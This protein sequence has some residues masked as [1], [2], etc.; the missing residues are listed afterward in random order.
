MAKHL[1]ISLGVT[2]D[3]S[4]AKAQLQDL[5]NQLTKI[6]NSPTSNRMDLAKEIRE[7][8]QAAAELQAHLKNAT[9]VDTGTL[10]FTKLSSSLKQSGQSLESYA[11]KLVRI[12]PEGRQAFQQLTTSVAQSEIPIKRVNK[13]LTEMWTTLKNSARWQISSSILHGFMGSVSKAYGYAQD[14]N[15]SLTNIRIVTGQ[16]TDQMA[17]FAKQANAAAK[18]L[19]TTTTK[20]TN[21]SLIY[22][23]QGLSDEEVKKR[24]DITVKMAN[25]A[26]ASAETVSD[27]LTAVWN[28]FY[29]GTKSLEHYADVMTAL[30]AA[31]ASSTDEIAG[32]LEKFAAVADTIGL[33]YEYAAS[34]LATITSNTRQSEEVVGTALKTIFARIQGLNLGETLEDGTSLNKYSAALE[35]VGISIFD[36]TG[37]LKEMD[38]ILDEL[39]NKWQTL[40]KDQQVA[41]A[42][43]VAGVRQ[44][45]QLVSLMDNWNN[46]DNDSF[47]ANLNTAKNSEG[48]LQEQADIYAEGW[49]AA[50]DRV[51]ASMEG[52][53]ETIMDDDAFI[54]VLNGIAEVVS[55]VDNL[56]D[57]M[58]GLGG[59]VATVGAVMTKVFSKQMAQSLRDT[60]YSLTMMTEK[61]RD[62]A[63]Q[64]KQTQLDNLTNVA[65]QSQGKYK[66]EETSAWIEGIESTSRAQQAYDNAS[67]HMTPEQAR[68]AQA[69]MDELARR[70]KEI[71]E[72]AKELDT[73]KNANG[74][75]N[76]IVENAKRSRAQELKNDGGNL[77]SDQRK[78]EIEKT[79]QAISKQY[80]EIKKKYNQ[81][82]A[83]IETVINKNT[84]F[85]DSE[86]IEK[87]DRILEN[88]PQL[89]NKVKT[90]GEWVELEDISDEMAND[91]FNIRK[92]LVEEVEEALRQV[93]KNVSDDLQINDSTL[94]TI[95]EGMVG[96]AV[97]EEKIRSMKDDRDNFNKE[98]IDAMNKITPTI[99]DWADKTVAISDTLFTLTSSIQ[100]LKGINE[101]IND[102]TLSDWDKFISI[103][104]TLTMNIP[105]LINSITNLGTAFG[106]VAGATK[107]LNAAAVKLVPGFTAM[108]T[109][110]GALDLTTKGLTYSLSA[111]W[112]NLLPVI[113]VL[114][115]AAVAIG[116]VYS[117]LTKEQRAADEAAESA[118]NL[119]NA[120]ESAK[121]AH[122]AFKETLG[123]YNEEK[124]ALKDLVYGTEEYKE[125]LKQANETALELI[126]TN[127]YLKDKYY[128]D[129]KGAIQFADNALEEV[130]AQKEQTRNQAE[131]TS[132]YAKDYA[133][134]L[135][136]K[137][138]KTALMRADSSGLLTK[139]LINQ[140]AE[141]F[142][143]DSTIFDKLEAGKFTEVAELLKVSDNVVGVL[144]QHK[145]SLEQLVVATNN[146]EATQ[147]LNN[148]LLGQA[149]FGK[150]IENTNLD[151]SSKQ[152]LLA[153]ILGDS[154]S[155]NADKYQNQYKYLSY[156]EQESFIENYAREQG[157]ASSKISLNGKAT[158]Y[159]SQGKEVSSLTR[160]DLTSIY[161]Y[162]K[163]LEETSESIEKLAEIVK[164]GTENLNDAQIE[165]LSTFSDEKIGDLSKLTKKEIEDLAAGLEDGFDGLTEAIGATDIETAFEQA[166]TNLTEAKTEFV[167][168]LA[169][170]DESTGLISR[171]IQNAFNELDTSNVSLEGSKAIGN[172]LKNAF[173][174]GGSEG[175][176]VAKTLFAAAGDKAGEVANI[177]SSIDWQ[178]ATVETLNERL[179][180]AGIHI[181]QASSALAKFVDWI[182]KVRGAASAASNSEFYNSTQEILEKMKS[183]GTITEEEMSV[184]RNGS[185]EMK[186]M[187]DLFQYN[188]DGTY[189]Y[190][191]TNADSYQAEQY[192]KEEYHNR[193]GKSANEFYQNA[194]NIKAL[195]NVDFEALTNRKITD[196]ATTQQRILA[197]RELMWD[198]LDKKSQ[199][200]IAEFEKIL[201]EG[202]TL[203]GRQQKSLTNILDKNS[204]LF[205][206]GSIDAAY[207]DNMFEANKN[208]QADFSTAES[209][210]Q[211]EEFLKKYE[212]VPGAIEAA[213]K[214]IQK[215]NNELLSDE[216]DIEKEELDKLA[217][218]Y[219]NMGDSAEEAYKKAEEALKLN[220]GLE[221]LIDNWKTYNKVLQEGSESSPQFIQTMDELQTILSNITGISDKELFTKDWIKKNQTTL[222]QLAKGS[223]KAIDK[224]RKAAADEILVK[225][226]GV[227][228]FDQVADDFKYLHNYL[229]EY[230]KNNSIEVG[231]KID[232]A[233]FL[234][235]CNEIIAAAGFTAEQA[236]EY[237]KAL[238][239]N[240]E[241]ETQEK[242]EESETTF[243]GQWFDETT[244]EIK[245]INTTLKKKST[246]KVPVV[247]SITYTGEAGGK[248]NFSNTAAGGA[249]SS[250]SGGGSSDEPTKMEY[251]KEI[252]FYDRYKEWDDALDDIDDLLS[253]IQKKEDSLYGN[254]KISAMKNRNKVLLKEVEA[255]QQKKKEAEAYF[256]IDK[257]N[258]QNAAGELGYNIDF[259]SRDQILNYTSTMQGLFDELHAMEEHFNSLGS[260]K[261]QQEYK[262][263]VMDPFNQ[264]VDDLKT[265]I[266]QYDE[267]RELLEDLENDIDDSILEWKGLNYE[268]LHY[269]MEIKIEINDVALERLDYYLSKY[270]DDFYSLAEAASTLFD[271]LT[272]TLNKLRAY[273][274]FY[275]DTTALW[276]ST[277]QQ[278]A[279]IVDGVTDATHAA[280]AERLDA[281][282]GGLIGA[283]TGEGVINNNIGDYYQ[284][285]GTDNLDALS[286]DITQ[287]DYAE[288]LKEVI[289]GM[290]EELGNLDE[291]DK[292]F[293]EFY[294]SALDMAREELEF[295]TGSLTHLT[296]ALEHYQKVADI[297]GRTNDY[298]FM[299]K[300]LDAQAKAIENELSVASSN[301]EMMKQQK[302]HWEAM[303]A[304]AEM[305][306]AEWEFYQE[307]LD[308]AVKATEEAQEEMLA[309]TE[310]WAQALR[311]ILEKELNDAARILEN[312]L[313]GGTSF[314]QLNTTLERAESLQE[315]YLTDTNKIYETNKLI[316]QTQ[317]EIDRTTNNSAKLRLN[318]FI[319]ETEQLQQQNRLSEYELSIQQ[320]KYQLLLAELAVEEAKN[321][322]ST[323][324]LQRDFEGNFGYVYTADQDQIDDAMQNLD[325]KRNELYNIG[326]EGANDYT[327]K[328]LSTLDAMYN[329]FNT[330]QQNY[331]NGMYESE[332]EYQNAMTEAYDYYFTKL[333]E[334]EELYGI[335]IR[336][337]SR[338]TADAWSTDFQDMIYSTEIWADECEV[339]I[340]QVTELFEE[341]GETSD[342][343]NAILEDT[344]GTIDDIVRASDELADS[345]NNNVVPGLQQELD[346]LN[347]ILKAYGLIRDE[348]LAEQKYMEEQAAK[349]EKDLIEE[350]ERDGYWDDDEIEMK[351]P[352][353][354]SKK[355]PTSSS[356]T[357]TSSTSNNN[358]SGSGEKLYHVWTYDTNSPDYKGTMTYDE[359]KQTIQNS[360]DKEGKIYGGGT[361]QG[362]IVK[363]FVQSQKY[364]DDKEKELAAQMATGGYTGAWGPE[365]KTAILHEKELVLNK[366]DTQNILEAVDMVRQISTGI[367]QQASYQRIATL[368]TQTLQEKKSNDV[369]EQ[370][371]T[372]EARFDNVRD[373]YEIEA[374]FDNLI[375]KAS[376]YANRNKI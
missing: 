59:V 82:L 270:E 262:K 286:R 153:N 204:A 184:L 300:L 324:R 357:T 375:N 330:I 44:Y 84:S 86:D 328:Y 214:Q 36:T 155:T 127:Q 253:D 238:G 291:I 164:N 25:A 149:Q 133:E 29:D 349:A 91:I 340:A 118:K 49:E 257:Q 165:A 344:T 30:G 280:N 40:G 242:T 250:S 194:Q 61:G 75:K 245:D 309:K 51:R 361:N 200:M 290:Y 297:T 176:T 50:S 258:L 92:A 348:V 189:A 21:A 47:Q 352:T 239:Y 203:S 83:D 140:V 4:K 23:Q 131:A 215:L 45:N 107:L 206:Q 212:E 191:G 269:E 167:N 88:N 285:D 275:K 121:E 318:T 78:A 135:S 41:L 16:N 142:K 103:T 160:Q 5:Q 329:E 174:E 141:A 232:N 95:A 243:D 373:R 367:D 24:T 233:Q 154:M 76:Q 105:M 144:N 11:Q 363:D 158:F 247:K 102:D 293:M 346:L 199:I 112:T 358:N 172:V 217:K 223:T 279:D 148:T 48:A 327:S 68:I 115:A 283:F 9:N 43:T 222:D 266:D 8:S 139:D 136:I 220:K 336:T 85:F 343:L 27:Q 310:E 46:G 93:Q 6:I 321:A 308:A 326:L 218:A 97:E 90:Q 193:F 117:A 132:I 205:N 248:V 94:K 255:L 362:T 71:E 360:A 311:N 15:E 372:I 157:Y 271:K 119:E 208:M 58:G 259:G 3:T 180:D 187:T 101:V 287:A 14:L 320:A 351:E 60:A 19:S 369:L 190:T 166:K 69:N 137:A 185:T 169:I 171:S 224:I 18:A 162:Q 182:N 96:E 143:K 178:T 79:S 56:I 370:H 315:E 52:I 216:L 240:V 354:S 175:L 244:G 33:S 292:Q 276:D 225:V 177:V 365:G 181:P 359:A 74:Y 366:T 198:A 156:S 55:Y 145:E 161:A 67:K 13:Q 32:G 265:Y 282:S 304:T 317:Q 63:R 126:E 81:S 347:E 252:D 353:G 134:D 213:E 186:Q 319:T 114:G 294:A 312:A 371:V 335:A 322:K 339:Y 260:G 37:E 64:Q 341:W 273:D 305:G 26:G 231:A 100:A 125:A 249:G 313:T 150:E 226:S 364:F 374:A 281:M 228:S 70:N 123:K 7:A 302:A 264:K 296:K 284:S 57:S 42:Q 355:A 345:I 350:A 237:F 65:R 234:D 323:V 170:T 307:N 241:V 77:N 124:E 219:M 120:Y 138:Q 254:S 227:E 337:D 110:E 179:V 146:N 333:K 267:T 342:D 108:T 221:E 236:G 89:K 129:D 188:A 152:N 104:S 54:A 80:D 113:A 229:W 230:A 195:E 325:D 210:E 202:G 332:T 211:V 20:Y 38:K 261:A 98:S 62:K 303:L 34:A 334:Y 163:G 289:S 130:E 99:T 173:I 331:L 376:Q 17:K 116:L 197:A 73:T 235:A 151:T 201:A 159:D 168:S 66:T 31:T 192:F 298:E 306:S 12:G 1:N 22:Y 277:T 272:P 111:L 295:Y 368:I 183:G 128:F 301:Y 209:I 207:E 338:V 278:Y 109:A 35:S 356:T 2:A 268:I 196:D 274:E 147:R 314:D 87:L 299:G 122:L 39:G 10:D 53:Y 263:N 288:G 251:T 28:N 316:R 72:A 106:G 256:E 246:I